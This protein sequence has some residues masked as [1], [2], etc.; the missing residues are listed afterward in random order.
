M[1]NNCFLLTGVAKDVKTGK[2]IKKAMYIDKNR[3]VKTLYK[4]DP[5]NDRIIEENLQYYQMPYWRAKAMLDDYI[6]SGEAPTIGPPEWG[7]LTKGAETLRVSLWLEDAKWDDLYLLCVD[8]D[9]FHGVIGETEF[10]RKCLSLC[11]FHTRSQGGGYHCWFGVRR[12]LADR[13]FEEI[14]LTTH[15]GTKSF[16]CAINL[17]SDGNDKFDVFCC[18]GRL[19]HEHEPWQPDRGV[20][21]KT[22]ELYELFKQ[23]VQI[24]KK[25][26]I[27]YWEDAE[28]KHIV[29]EGMDE[30][31]LR[32]KARETKWGDKALLILDDL[33]EKDAGCARGPWFWVGCNIK[34]VFDEELGGSVWLWW[35]RQGENYQPQACVNTW[36]EICRR[37]VQL[38][39]YGWGQILG[40]EVEHDEAN[41]FDFQITQNEEQ[42]KKNEYKKRR[43]AEYLKTTPWFQYV[44]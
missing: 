43:D 19:V 3:K 39:D 41:A 29:L 36:G 44:D 32:E 26:H 25:E 27:D 10:F 12:P 31:T 7:I 18:N 21:D 2:Q 17:T 22:Q 9:K 23:Y 38:L 30:E 1:Y 40:V 16:V 28:G 15:R 8:F 34:E 14:N 33:K 13:L 5:K 35:S 37:K 20:S 4:W 24:K 42:R 11:D 6:Y